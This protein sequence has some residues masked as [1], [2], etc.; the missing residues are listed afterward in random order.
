MGVKMRYELL[1][2]VRVVHSDGV[3][4]LSARKMEIL[5]AVLLARADQVVT[6]GQLFTELWGE[7]A[8]RRANASLHVYV[9][10]LRKFLSRPGRTDS[11]IVTHPPGYLLR[12]GVDDIDALHFQREVTRGRALLAV[13]DHEAAIPVF[14]A[15]LALWRGP[16]LDDLRDGPIVNG[17]VTW[18]EE[19]RVDCLEML[20]EAY[21]KCGRHREV[22]GRLQTLIAEH[23]LREAFYRYLMLALYHSERRAEA[24]Q[25]YQVARQRL[26]DELGLEPCRS[27]RELQQDI[28]VGDGSVGMLLGRV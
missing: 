13:G 1:G 6:T 20:V 11:P 16:A 15:A 25:L 9:S 18:L 7:Q 14:E 17:Y 27:L 28:L 22:I 8:P 12:I 21:L 19:S 5:L 2:S 10:Q 24:L 26:N 23:P 4:I 3:T